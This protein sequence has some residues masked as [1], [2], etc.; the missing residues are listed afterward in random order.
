MIHPKRWQRG[1]A[2][3]KEENV[4]GVDFATEEYYLI[5]DAQVEGFKSYRDYE[6]VLGIN[7]ENL[8]IEKTRC[9]CEDYRE[10]NR[11]GTYICK[12]IEVTLLEAMEIM[13]NT[14]RVEV[15]SNIH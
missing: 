6:S 8:N 13:E 7:L 14:N 2:Y 5:I 12:H 15:L 1:N 10:N 9:T 11:R 4:Y 3:Y